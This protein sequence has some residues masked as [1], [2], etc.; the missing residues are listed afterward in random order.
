MPFITASKRIRYL[1]IILIDEI[2]DLYSENCKT[3]M[4]KI[5]YKQM[6]WHLIFM[7]EKT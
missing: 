2:K 6:E 4:K 7:D 1:G 5:K 3:L